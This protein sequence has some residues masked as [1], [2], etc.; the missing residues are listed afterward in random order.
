[1]AIISAT[2]P[3]TNDFGYVIDEDAGSIGNVFVPF[4]VNGTTANQSG[5]ITQQTDADFY[6][7]KTTGGT[8]TSSRQA[9]SDN[10]SPNLDVQLAPTCQAF[11]RATTAP[12]LV[13]AGFI[14]PGRR[15][16]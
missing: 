7:F 15:S 12:R 10:P 11:C 9:T 8:V 3:G 13:S 2:G 16:T 5:I 6:G 14:T 4:P 1:M